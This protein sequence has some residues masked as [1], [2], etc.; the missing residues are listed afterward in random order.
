MD[1]AVSRAYRHAEQ[2][3]DGEGDRA[4]PT[5]ETRDAKCAPRRPAGLDIE[6]EGVDRRRARGSELRSDDYPDIGLPP[7]TFRRRTDCGRTRIR[8]G[9][10]SA[11]DRR[12]RRV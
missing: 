1:L 4:Q 8:A 7:P 5:A 10:G 11:H 3:R 2:T 6:C 12:P 9:G